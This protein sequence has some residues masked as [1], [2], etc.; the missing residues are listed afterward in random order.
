L[1]K[2]SDPIELS[3][4]IPAL[5]EG[6]NLR[7]LLPEINEVLMEMSIA[8]E[9]IVIDEL[10]DDQIRRVIEE[11]N[12]TLLSPNCHGYGNSL[13]AGIRTSAG[14]YIITMDADFSHPPQFIKDLWINKSIGDVVI[15]SRYITGGRAIMPISRYILSRI[16]NIFFSRGLDLH[17]RDMS[18][19]FRLYRSEVINNQVAQNVNF[20]IVQELLVKSLVEGYK[21]S[22]IPFI[23]HPRKFGSSHARV[24]RFGL[25]YLKTFAKLWKI[26]NSIASA[27]YDAR[28]YNTF[29]LP[30]RIWQRK[31]FKYVTG[32]IKDKKKCLDVGCGT[33]KILG[34]L[35][36]GSVALDILIR[37]LRY[38]RIYNKLLIQGTALS[39]PFESES[40]DCV[41]CSQVIEHIPRS[42]VL[43]ELD[44][45]LK[46]SGKLILGTPDYGKWQWIVIEW[47][48]KHILPQAYA[49]EHITQYTLNELLEEFVQNRGYTLEDRRYIFQGELILSLIKA[50]P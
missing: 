40:F 18:S 30:Q 1:Q 21:I 36:P 39:L 25:D 7:Y 23:Y 44:R 4:V 50:Y 8:Y 12:A 29:L 10:A 48:Y 16:L 3:I 9:I 24:I 26:R 22:E 47:L 2:Y 17:V 49:D 20:D 28:A 19:G 37:K 31:R 5:N 34:T 46:P 32:F 14:R 38:A 27:D 45:V 35:P 41:I 6:E 15:A 11:N 13:I 42:S 43:D 33:S